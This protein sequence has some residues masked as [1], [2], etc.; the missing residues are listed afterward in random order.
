MFTTPRG[1]MLTLFAILTLVGCSVWGQ[2][3][4]DDA[5]GRASHNNRVRHISSQTRSEPHPV[6][7]WQD[8][9]PVLDTRCVVCHSCYD[10]PCQLDLSAHEGIERGANKE[11]VYA[12]ARLTA[13]KP[14]RLFVDAHSVKAWRGLGFFPVLNERHQS[15]TANIKASLMANILLLKQQNPLPPVNPL[16][17]SFDFS[18]DRD[19]QQ[20]PT[21]E[22]FDQFAKNKPL[23]GMPYGLPNLAEGELNT[24]LDWIKDGAPYSQPAPLAQNFLS[25]ITAWETFLNGA[26]LKEQ[27]MSRYLYEHLFLAHLY[28]D[29]LSSEQFFRMVRSKTPPGEPI[30]FVTSL[31]PYDDPGV[32]RVYYRI[33]PI[34]RTILAK[35]HMPYALNKKRKK[36]YK[37]L[38]LKPEIKVTALSSYRAEVAA[39]PFESF[40]AIPIDSRY[41]FLLDEAQF[42][43][44]NFLKGP[45]CRGQ[46]ALNVINEQF[47]VFFT[48]PDNEI[49]KQSSNFIEKERHRLKMPTIEAS[50]TGVIG[51]WLKYSELEKEYF[52]KKVQAM[53][54]NLSKPG[55]ISLDL[56]W[57]GDGSND[58]AALTIFRHLNNGTVEKGL[59]GDK[60]KTAIVLTYA[61]LERIHYL[62][63]A[64]Y[65]IYGNIGH[66]MTSRLYM[67][68][69]RMEG[70]FNFLTLLPQ[71]SR[72]DVWADWYRGA[73]DDVQ[74]YMDEYTKYFNQ[75][76]SISYQ[77]ESPKD[78]LLDKLRQHVKP[79]LNT[80]FELDTEET[81]SDETNKVAAQLKKLSQIKGLPV[82]WLPQTM[83]LTIEG[84]DRP[85]FSLI[86]NNGM[87]NVS[88]LFFEAQRR[89]PQEDTLTVAPGFLGA[90][91]NAFYRVQTSELS[92]FVSAVEMLSSEADYRTLLTRFGL[93]RTDPA[94]WRHSDFLNA[95]Y[96][97]T[98]PLAAGLLDYSRLEN[99]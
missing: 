48:N 83:I 64:G 41:R 46:V 5:Y 37:S 33:E 47:W 27:L 77:T 86:R 80:A 43:L 17:P 72:K 59:I 31:R 76:T 20:C 1:L 13:I 51:T 85:V 15:E 10:A 32:P 89:R 16:P 19:E 88:E 61:L 25:E 49:I 66:Q 8:V 56:V 6:D 11:V 23:W 62:L 69:M 91:P 73:D 21:I 3:K 55:E 97:E 92:H 95:Y 68:F 99:R 75:E 34:H 30:D 39:N 81:N 84:L 4:L 52:E 57:D 42:T 50:N 22:T 36:R 40:E 87:S 14:T 63:V 54:K 67:D 96:R 93:Q 45:V 28:F 98:A 58:N 44:M 12:P 24:L 38:F 94:F 65:D 2:I 35:T 7:F 60:P 71:K 74:K 78:E 29:D 90:H 26:S 18:L 53:Q 70:E 79:A 82:S 9:K